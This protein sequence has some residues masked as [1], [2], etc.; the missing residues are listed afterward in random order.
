MKT[1]TKI[2]LIAIVIVLIVVIWALAK[3]T[4][5]ASAYDD[6]ARCLADK[7]AK[8][9]GAEW[10]PHCQ[11]Q[12]NAFGSSFKFVPYVECP[13]SPQLCLEAGIEGYPT[14]ILPS[15]EKLLGEQSFEVLA[16]KTGC[17]LPRVS[18]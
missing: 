17:A 7:G 16:E 2:I 1:K 6:F 8:M 15:G 13:Q 12:K 4:T 10:C 3:K 11:T 9:Y 18:K 5:T 14:W